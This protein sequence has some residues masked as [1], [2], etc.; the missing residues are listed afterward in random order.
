MSCCAF[1]KD[2]KMVAGALQDGSIQLWKACGPFVSPTTNNHTTS[3]HWILLYYIIIIRN[4]LPLVFSWQARSSLQQFGA[5][6]RGSDT[7][8]LC[9][10]HDNRTLVSRGGESV[11]RSSRQHCYMPR[12]HHCRKPHGAGGLVNLTLTFKTHTPPVLYG[13]FAHNERLLRVS[14]CL[15]V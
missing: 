11:G 4:I 6:A 2:G 8:S 9:F 12:T 7:S 10:S 3:Q 13:Q 14:V 1:T 5:H 15:S